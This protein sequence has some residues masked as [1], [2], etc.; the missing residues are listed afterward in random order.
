MYNLYYRFIRRME[1]LLDLD[2][3]EL[4]IARSNTRDS[5]D[6][7]RSSTNSNSSLVEV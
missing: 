5:E 2:E 1:E 3:S 4:A 7:I 6:N